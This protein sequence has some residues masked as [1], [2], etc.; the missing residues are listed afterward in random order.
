[1]HG[2]VQDLSLRNV[3]DSIYSG[4]GDYGKDVLTT[5]SFER[6]GEANAADERFKLFFYTKGMNED[7][8]QIRDD[9]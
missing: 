9:K 6:G 4:P 7:K 5:P 8:Q 2:I 3:E 1:M